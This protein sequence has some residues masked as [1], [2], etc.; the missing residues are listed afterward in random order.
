MGYREIKNALKNI[1]DDACERADT[2][3]EAEGLFKKLNQLDFGILTELWSTTT[4]RFK[5]TSTMLQAADLDL[6]TAA[7]LMQSLTDYISSLR[8]EFELFERKVQEL[9][10]NDIFNKQNARK[11][12]RSTRITFH[13]GNKEEVCLSLREH[14]RITVFL[15]IIDRSWLLCSSVL[16]RIQVFEISS[17]SYTI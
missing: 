6:N 16:L 13:E 2:K 7:S 10:I 9:T 12:V 14:F 4:E 11:R 15:Q 17:P 8:S 1:R 5:D 3:R